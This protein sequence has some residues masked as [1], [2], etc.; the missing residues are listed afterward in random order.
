MVTQTVITP[1]DWAYLRSSV[2]KCNALTACDT[3]T[4][5]ECMHASSDQ[6]IIN[7]TS[8]FNFDSYMLLLSLLYFLLHPTPP[9]YKV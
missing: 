3:R 1:C 2:L 5:N 7:L 6:R 8:T 9:G 4:P